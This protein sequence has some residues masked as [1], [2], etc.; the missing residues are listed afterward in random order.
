MKFHR[1]ACLL[2]IALFG[3]LVG[4]CDKPEGTSANQSPPPEAAASPAPHHPPSTSD[5]RKPLPL[6]AHMAEHQRE[7]MRDHL[8][9]IQEILA[10]LSVN[11]FEG[12]ERAAS[13]IGYSE[14]MGRMCSHMGAGA[15]GFTDTALNFHRTADTIG[16]AAKQRDAGATLKAVSATLQTCVGC[17][18]TY[19]QEIVDEAKWNELTKAAR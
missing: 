19:R 11:D 14:Q 16:T 1:T 9:A 17:H 12:V 8:A 5:T 15:P 3:T 7:N 18:A 10:A 13:R 4:G 6:L 2:S